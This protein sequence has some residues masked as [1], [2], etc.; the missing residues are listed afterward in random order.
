MSSGERWV[1]RTAQLFR[2]AWQV[3]LAAV[4][5]AVAIAGITVT[6][7]A[8]ST[9]LLSPSQQASRYLGESDAMF[10]LPTGVPLGSDTAPLKA[11]LH[12]AVKSGGG[13]RVSV[14]YLLFGLR[15]DDAAKREIALSEIGDLST[16]ASQVDLDS[17]YEPGPLA[18]RSSVQR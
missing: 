17:R 13:S 12:D 14:D 6:N 8:V 9:L 5:I 18:K 15:T 2:R 1:W 10:Q 7:F 3:R 4:F 11:Q 16:V